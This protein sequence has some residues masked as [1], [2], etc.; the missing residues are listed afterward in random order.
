MRRAF[1]MAS[2]VVAAGLVSNVNAATLTFEGLANG[3]QVSGQFAAMPGSPILSFTGGANNLGT[4]IFDST[5][6]GVN[7]GG[8]DP[9]LLVNLGNV[10]ILQSPQSPA[11]TGNRFDVPNDS[12]VGA[13]SMVFTFGSAVRPESI[14]LVDV[15]RHVTLDVIMTDSGGN[16]R[17]FDVPPNWTND[18]SDGVPN[19]YDVLDLTE[20][21]LAQI[22]E[23]G[24]STPHATTFG[25]FN[26]FDVRRLE[27]LF[28]GSSPSGAIDNLVYTPEPGTAVLVGCGLMALAR[29][30]RTK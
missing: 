4:A 23:G 6:P 26:E 28:Q 21:L 16:T 5:N 15:D 30:R 9:D 8:P 12:N 17:K 25:P 19:G 3:E 1:Q 22:G 18:I 20:T 14:T 11:V 10:L 7:S 2:V 27:V 24:T 29:R 13:G